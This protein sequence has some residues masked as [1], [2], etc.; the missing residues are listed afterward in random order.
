MCLK[1][2]PGRWSRDIGRESPIAGVRLNLFTKNTWGHVAMGHEYDD[3]IVDVMWH[4][5]QYT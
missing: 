3:D 2:G 5:L 1:C 4:Y